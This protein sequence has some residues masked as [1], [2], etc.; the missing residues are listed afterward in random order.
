MYSFVHIEKNLTYHCLNPFASILNARTLQEEEILH[1][2]HY[3]SFLNYRFDHCPH[4]VL[5]AKKLQGRGT[6]DANCNEALHLI[7]KSKLVASLLC[8]NR[9]N[10]WHTI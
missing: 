9:I 8:N 10:S 5:L 7:P 4:T 2:V 6:R 3:C 1:Q